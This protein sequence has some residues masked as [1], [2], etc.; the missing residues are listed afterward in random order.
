MGRAVEEVTADY[1]QK[2]NSF[3]TS[4]TELP[5]QDFLNSISTTATPTD[6]TVTGDTVCFN[7]S[8]N[9]SANCSTE[10]IPLLRIQ[11]TETL[12]D[13]GNASGRTYLSLFGKT[14]VYT[15][16]SREH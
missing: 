14:R 3:T 10:Q 4:G 2:V 11:V 6:L 15:D 5:V 16:P 1:I 13:L 12:A 9:L 8:G 7:S